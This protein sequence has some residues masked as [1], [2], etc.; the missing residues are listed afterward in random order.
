MR[1]V[2]YPQRLW[3]R[4]K[5][6]G[7]LNYH[8][9][10]ANEYARVQTK[11]S[12]KAKRSSRSPKSR[13]SATSPYRTSAPPPLVLG[14]RRREHPARVASAPAQTW[15]RR[16]QSPLDWG[17]PS[18]R[19]TGASPVPAA[20]PVRASS[21]VLVQMRAGGGEPSPKQ[22]QPPWLPLWCVSES[23]RVGAKSHKI[24]Q[25]PMCAPD[26]RMGT[27]RADRRPL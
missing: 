6:G 11:H 21:L 12:K 22:T 9:A 26:V 8:S 14:T 15:K 16:A 5:R 7:T 24:P 13:P 2:L 4:A 3:L 19:W 1:G 23:V 20:D 18:P 17:E 25:N 27:A 10:E